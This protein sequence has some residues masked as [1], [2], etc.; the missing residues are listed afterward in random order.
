MKPIIL[1]PT[2]NE[3]DS[4]GRLLGKLED[5]R[6]RQTFD[7]LIID[8]GSPDG[9]VDYI[10]SLNYPWVE[11]MKR[12]AKSGLGPAYRAGFI[13]ILRTRPEITHFVTMDADGSHRVED[14][15]AMFA[16]VTSGPEI[17]LGTRWMPGGAVENWPLKR[18]ILS[19]AGTTYARL[20]LRIPLRDLTGGFRIYSRELLESLKLEKMQ[21]S[22]YCYQIE[23]AL[24]ARAAGAKMREVPITFVERLHGRS[25]MTKEIVREA[26]FQT[27]HWGL[28]RLLHPNA[29]KLHYVK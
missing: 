20:A 2:Y 14:L 1:I 24:V 10:D 9:T 12:S 7:A 16:S 6:H 27:T 25:K 8:D 26:I 4:I 5:F 21:A 17:I 3:R 22:G 15:D 18:H 11:I 23:M 29:D 13:H 19:R 28:E